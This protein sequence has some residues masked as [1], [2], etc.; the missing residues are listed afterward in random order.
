[1]HSVANFVA[2]FSNF[3]DSF[4]DFFF[5]QNAPSDQS[6]GFAQALFLT[7]IQKSQHSY[8][9][10]LMCSLFDFIRRRHDYK[11]G[12][13]CRLLVMFGYVLMGRVSVTISY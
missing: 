12:F 8:C 11:S 1:M 2:R 10:Y 4:S 9:L 13:L 7:K 6:L 5:F 3:S